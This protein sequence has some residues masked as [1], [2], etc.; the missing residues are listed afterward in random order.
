MKRHR[1]KN[2][3]KAHIKQNIKVYICEIYKVL[4][5]ET[6]TVKNSAYLYDLNNAS[7]LSLF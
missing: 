4:F 7:L 3:I 1:N 5:S 6:I 2:R